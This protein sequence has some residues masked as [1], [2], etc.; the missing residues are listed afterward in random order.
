MQ[1]G[2]LGSMVNQYKEQ[3]NI[4]ADSIP[5]TTTPPTDSNKIETE[6]QNTSQ[7]QPQSDEPE[8]DPI[9]N[10]VDDLKQ[11]ATTT[12][13]APESSAVQLNSDVE[14]DPSSESQGLLDEAFAV[15]DDDIK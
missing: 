14:L 10:L 11:K 12:T 7:N 3:N 8:K 9:Q 4:P 6:A 5:T 1:T 13:A 2:D 15:I